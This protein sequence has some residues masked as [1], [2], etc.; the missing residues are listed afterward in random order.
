MIAFFLDRDGVINSDV[1]FMEKVDR[2]DIL[3]NAAAGIKKLNRMGLV[4]VVT[5]QPSVARKIFSEEHLNELHEKMKK[6]L[7]LSDAKIDAIYYCPHHPEKNHKDITPEMMKYR[8]DCACR[9]PKTGMLE[10]AAAD[11]NLNLKK[12]F[13]I[14]DRTVDI[15]TGK[16]AGCGTILVRTGLAGNDK[17]HDIIPDFVCHDLKDAAD[18]L[19]INLHTKAIIMAGGRGERMR[20]LTDKLPKP[21]LP[22][23]G[24]P[25]LEH[26]IE[27]LKKN[28]ITKIVIC[29]HYLFGMIKDYFGSGERFGVELEY[30][31][32]EIPMGTGGA[33][34]NAEGLI[35]TDYFFVFNGDTMTEINTRRLF[36]FHKAKDGLGTL[37]LRHS[38]HPKDSDIVKIDENERLIGFIGRG[39]T[40]MDIANTGIFVFSRK[41]LD[42]IPRTFCAIERDVIKDLYKTENFYGYITDEYIKDMGTFDRYESVKKR[43]EK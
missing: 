15:K 34:K 18:M 1:G 36:E 3:P 12:C 29:G 42:F 25:V 38:D 11:F 41:I 21:M 27:L 10:Q 37:V 31:D 22:I 13:I 9:K 30:M 28:G 16:D 14:G 39:Q 8:I 2:L 43:Y 7:A 24:K 23:A 4:I 17:K 35:T 32:E 33:I 40:E 5:N 6:E 26:Q 20:P 19:D